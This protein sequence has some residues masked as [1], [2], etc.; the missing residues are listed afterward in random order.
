MI[1]Y[2]TLMHHQPAVQG[3]SV[4]VHDVAHAERAAAEVLSLPFGPYMSESEVSRV[5]DALKKVLR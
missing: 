4:R 5:A 1:H 3:R 2:E